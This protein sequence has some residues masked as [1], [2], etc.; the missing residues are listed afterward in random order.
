M[1]SHSGGGVLL[2]VI[3]AIGLASYV[4]AEMLSPLLYI[5]LVAH[6]NFL[7]DMDG[8]AILRRDQRDYAR[9]T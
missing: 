7:C 8:G 4:E 2:S 1:F 9:E 3:R 6:A 5:A